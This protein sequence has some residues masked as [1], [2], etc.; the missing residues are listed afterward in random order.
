MLVVGC[1]VFFVV[2]W[3]LFVGWLV[4]VPSC[5]FRSA[6][7]AKDVSDV[8]CCVR[9]VVRCLL[10]FVCLWA[11]AV[12]CGCLL[13]FGGLGV[14]VCVCSLYVLCVVP[15]GS[16]VRL[17]SCGVSRLL[18][19]VGRCLF[20]VCCSLFGG[21]YL[22][23]VCCSLLVRFCPCFVDWSKIVRM[24]VCVQLFVVCWLLFV[25]CRPSAFLL[26]LLILLLPFLLSLFSDSD[27]P[28]TSL[29]QS[30][31]VWSDS[32]FSQTC[33]TQTSRVWSDSDFS[34]KSLTQTFRVWSDADLSQKCLTQTCRVWSDSD[35]AQKCLTQTFRVLV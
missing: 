1:R 6:F 9:C 12:R 5:L 22:S 19:V 13:G 7:V 25:V 10:L 14:F 26:I 33:L 34:Y 35:F 27:F 31:R 32:D 17:W 8:G 11:I 29:A 23:I 18:C 24:L 20:R 3:S 21:C 4:C 28:Q 30:F 16:F 2:G 15:R